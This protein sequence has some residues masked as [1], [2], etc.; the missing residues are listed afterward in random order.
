MRRRHPSTF[1]VSAHWVG[2]ART[3]H[4]RGGGAVRPLSALT[5]RTETQFAQLLSR[6]KKEE[7]LK[8]FCSVEGHEYD[9]T[10]IRHAAQML[11]I[12]P[13]AVRWLLSAPDCRDL[14]SA[15]LSEAT[16]EMN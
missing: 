4:F 14:V 6:Q 2:T 15:L 10:C 16:N 5:A 1:Q 7:T 13:L 8:V 12:Q 11:A 3:A 9:K